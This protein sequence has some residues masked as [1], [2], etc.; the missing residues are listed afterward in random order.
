MKPKGTTTLESFARESKHKQFY[1]PIVEHIT[2]EDRKKLAGRAIAGG[3]GVVMSH[4]YYE[5]GGKIYKQSDGGAMGLDLTSISSKIY[6]LTWDMDVLAKMSELGIV[7]V[8][9]KRYVD[10]I[11]V[12]MPGF[13]PGWYFDKERGV[14]AF[15]PKHPYSMMS[16]EIRTGNIFVD[17]A[18]SIDP[19]IQVE[20]DSPSKYENGKLPILDLEVWVEGGRIRHSFY[21]KSI[22][23]KYVIMQR[24]AMSTQ[25]KRNTLFQECLKRVTYTKGGP[26]CY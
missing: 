18:N 23:S 2:P 3:V 24:S 15:D 1:S 11:T 20:F 16:Y 26:W 22:A 21:R 7:I 5:V 6:M 19:E 14:M 8:L 4:H 13:Y 17:I 12:F 9:Y 10:D 25:T